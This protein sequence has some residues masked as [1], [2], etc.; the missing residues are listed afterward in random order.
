[1]KTPFL[2]RCLLAGGVLF[3]TMTTRAADQDIDFNQDLPTFTITLIIGAPQVINI[4]VLG[5]PGNVTWGFFGAPTPIGV[6]GGCPSVASNPYVCQGV[7]LTLPTGS[8]SSAATTTLNWNGSAPAS[9]ALDFSLIVDGHARGYHIDFR[10]PLD[11]TFVLDKSGSMGLASSGGGG[12]TRWDALKTAV[13]N[14]MLKL[15]NPAFARP[16][17]RVGLTFFDSGLT[18]STFGSSLVALD[19]GS[20]TLV[21]NAM[22][23]LSPS[24]AT[25]M[26]A[27]LTDGKAKLTDATRSRDILLFTDGEQNR[28]PLVNNNGCDIGGVAIN[29]NCP[30]LPGSSGNLKMFTIGIGNPSPTYLSTLQNLATKNGGNCLLTS[31]GNSFTNTTSMVVGDINAVFTQAFIDLLRNNSPQL[32]GTRIGTVG[33]ATQ[34]LIDFPLNKNVSELLIE[35]NLGKRFEIPQLARL[36]SDLRVSRNGQNVTA[37]GVPRWVGNA[38]DTYIL[39]FS[40]NT[41]RASAARI[42]SEGQWEVTAQP[43][44]VASGLPYRITVIADD[45]LLDYICTQQ[46]AQPTV[47]GTQRFVVQL[48]DRGKPMENATVTAAVYRPGDDIGDL[49]A[50]NSLKVAVPALQLDQSA[51]GILKYNALLARD[52][53]FVRALVPTEQVVTLTHRGNGRY[54][55]DYSGMNVAGIYQIMYRIRGNDSLRGSYDRYEMQSMYVEPGQIDL[56]KSVLHKAVV[57]GQLVMTLRPVTTYGRFIGPA[58]ADAFDVNAPSASLSNVV[59]NQDGSYTLTFRGNTQSN[60]TISILK[61][62]VYTGPLERLQISTRIPDVAKPFRPGIGNVIIRNPQINRIPR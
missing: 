57:N 34:R 2:R 58:A 35:I 46:T 7:T 20:A 53:A 16:G 17:D 37:L 33:T 44:S 62:P 42:R 19:P 15:S 26:G 24:G 59:D 11:I 28:A 51:V 25:A 52:P 9:G 40:F 47:G 13:N 29:T 60:A 41:A 30:V 49:M 3:Y 5:A 12:V 6:P 45:H 8:V 43:N 48:S 18:P 22:N 23:A 10:R 61:K 54:E 21:Q 4:G 1:M 38:P 39:V 56:D 50:R 14:F 32:V 27:G 31:N 36:V 55:G